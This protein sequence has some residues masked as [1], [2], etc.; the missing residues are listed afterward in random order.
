MGRVAAGED[1]RV[2]GLDGG[3]TACMYL[4]P[5]NHRLL[6]GEFYVVHVN[7][8]VVVSKK[9]NNNTIRFVNLS[10]KCRVRHSTDGDTPEPQ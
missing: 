10:G 7:N 8:F 3:T 1:K 2:P 9:E 5:Q 4:K 6:S